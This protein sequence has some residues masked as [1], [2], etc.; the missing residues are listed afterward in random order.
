MGKAIKAAVGIVL[1]VAGA[2]TGNSILFRAG[3]ALVLATA[4]EALAPNPGRL[5]G[6]SGTQIEYQGQVESRRMI[7]GLLRVSGLNVIPAWSNG[8]DNKYLH[9]VLAIAGHEVHS[10]T[11][12]YADQTLISSANIGSVTGSDSDGLVST[13]TYLNVLWIR[14][15]TGTSTQN[16]DFILNQAFSTGWNSNHRGRGIAY[17]ALRYAWDTEVYK[18]A[19]PEI[20]CIVKGKKC[21]DPRLDPSPGTN[22]TNASY[23]AWT[24]NPAL[25]IADYL[26]DNSLGLGEDATRIDWSL[27][28][29]AA[30]ICEESVSIPGPSTQ[31]RYT[32]N[33]IFE[34][35]DRYEDILSLL[36]SSMMGHVIYSGGKWRMYAGAW[37]SSAYSLT[38]DDLTGQ[39]EIVSEITRKEKF[40]FVRGWYV[41]PQRSYQTGEFQPQSDASY[42]AEDGERIPKEVQFA[43]CTNEYEAQRNAL[44]LLRRSRNREIA[45]MACGMSAYKIRPFETGDVTLPE[46]QWSAQSG[47]CIA[48]QFTPDGQASITHRE[49]YSSNWDDPDIGD[50]TVAS[51]GTAVSPGAYKPGP[52]LNVTAQGVTDGIE[53]HWD[54]PTNHIAGVVFEV[55]EYTSASP[56][57]SASKLRETPQASI[58]IARTDTTTRYYWIIGRYGQQYGTEAPI[59]SGIPGAAAA[60][61]SGFRAS[62]SP[63]SVGRTTTSSSS[64]TT[65]C[66]IIP[67]GGTSPYT[68]SWTRTGGDSST[69]ISSSTSGAVTFSRTS[70]VVDTSYTSTWDCV[71]T[72]NTS[73]TRTVT[74]S[75]WFQRY[76]PEHGA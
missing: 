52:A 62:A 42:E 64:T 8:T 58:T 29:A 74:V 25:C 67:V 43:A 57:S 45:T 21:Y 48:W 6:S 13:G 70:M 26:L 33:V 75:V 55:W 19:K 46:L 2:W 41:D 61:T 72:D 3:W 4:A 66:T 73:A 44:I 54:L 56:F 1:I 53:F 50:Y 69:T 51:A 35:T 24:Q 20:S 76:A 11:D 47:R 17:L 5:P 60:I 49:E 15:Y 68:Y 63:T 16:V 36:A 37:S 9:Q 32:C 71:V 10:I 28:A 30:N 7:Y 39:L 34:V 40:N 18:Q 38:Q 59:G 27:V 23:I 22:T 12:V 31:A 14:R 65:T